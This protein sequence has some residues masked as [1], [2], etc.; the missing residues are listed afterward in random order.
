MKTSTHKKHGVAWTTNDRHILRNCWDRGMTI[1]KIASQ[2][3]RSEPAVC[4]QLVNLGICF[5][6]EQVLSE[7]DARQ[8]LRD[9]M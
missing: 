4:M 7:S 2:L 5:D 3:K 6:E 1:P 9:T 8:R